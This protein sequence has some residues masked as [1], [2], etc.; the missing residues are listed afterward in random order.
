MLQL[1]EPGMSEPRQK[2]NSN[3]KAQL[4]VRGKVRNFKKYAVKFKRM[5]N[6]S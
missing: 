2:E 3:R 1:G 4:R 5:R 6:E